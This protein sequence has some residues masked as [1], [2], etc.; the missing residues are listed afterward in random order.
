MEYKEE[1]DLIAEEGRVYDC[2]TWE[3]R[4]EPDPV[5]Y[6]CALRDPDGNLVEFSYGQN[7]K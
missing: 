7:I 4:Q 1:V 5:G 3:P 2:L 6:V